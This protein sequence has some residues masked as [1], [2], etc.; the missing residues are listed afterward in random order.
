M[1]TGHVKIAM[2]APLVTPIR[3]PQLGGSQSLVADIARGLTARGHEVS[4]FAASGSCI[5]GVRVVDSGID[6]ETLSSTLFRA[7]ETEHI[8]TPAMAAFAEVYQLLA[9]ESFDIIHNHAFD[10]PAI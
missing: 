2:V 5:N 6:S 1:E 4:V 9:G 3:E 10:A 7:D 8:T